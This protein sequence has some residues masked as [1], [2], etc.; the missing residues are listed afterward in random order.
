MTELAVL[1]PIPTPDP[2]AVEMAELNDL[3]SQ[4]QHI[5]LR[6]SDAIAED[7]RLDA[8]E[9]IQLAHAGLALANTIV[10]LLVRNPDAASRER[11]LHAATRSLLVLNEAP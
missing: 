4:V 9:G 10:G 5:L 8:V 3:R 1:P 7:G 6:A 11:L 2:Y